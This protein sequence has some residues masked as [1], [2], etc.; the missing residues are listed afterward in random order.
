MGGAIIIIMVVMVG[1][2]VG[3]IR[4]GVFEEEE[5]SVRVLVFAV[6]VVCEED[7]FNEDAD[8]SVCSVFV[9]CRKFEHNAN[10]V[11]MNILSTNTNC[12]Q[13]FVA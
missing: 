2:I 1:G 7:N 4:F 12:A 3:G 10:M 6:P 9:G 13:K 5:E 8:I 11:S